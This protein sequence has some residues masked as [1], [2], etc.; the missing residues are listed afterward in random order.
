MAWIHSQTSYMWRSPALV[1]FVPSYS[2]FNGIS[3]F[4]VAPCSR[5]ARWK[6]DFSAPGLL[7]QTLY[8]SSCLIP[9]LLLHSVLIN[10]QCCI[11]GILRYVMQERNINIGQVIRLS[12]AEEALKFSNVL[13]DLSLSQAVNTKQSSSAENESKAKTV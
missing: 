1:G 4:T 5:M 12:T 6:L 3:S 13:S 7:S 8:I 10:R 11:E 9:N 2:H